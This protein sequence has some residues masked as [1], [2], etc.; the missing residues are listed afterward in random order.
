MSF[1]LNRLN[2]KLNPRTR[3]T[4]IVSII[5]GVILYYVVTILNNGTI[6]HK[7][8][9]WGVDMGYTQLFWAVLLVVYC[10]LLL[11]Y[12]R[13]K[14]FRS[15]TVDKLI[16]LFLSSP[17]F[18]IAGLFIFGGQFVFHD[19]N[20]NFYHH[21]GADYLDKVGHFIG[22]L[23]ITVVLMK[24]YPA[25]FA[26]IL[27]IWLGISYELFELL[28]IWNFGNDLGYSFAFEIRD[29]PLDIIAN[30]TGVIVGMIIAIKYFR[31]RVRG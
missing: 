3:D 27:A 19:P 18:F 13:Q 7:I 12:T 23:V 15:K 9:D 20:I 10:L 31:F 22:F 14:T 4:I 24:V 1:I 29:T 8:E 2:R 25:R 28:V 11:T 5:L 21:P 17:I 6:L 30:T 26:L 16:T